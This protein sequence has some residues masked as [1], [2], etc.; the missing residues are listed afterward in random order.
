MMVKTPHGRK[1]AKI[2]AMDDAN[3]YAEPA[4]PAAPI[5]VLSVFGVV[6]FGCVFWGIVGWQIIKHSL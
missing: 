4:R 1:V 6:A 3:E 5:G 2:L